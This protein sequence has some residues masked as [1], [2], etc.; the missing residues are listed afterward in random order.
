VESFGGIDRSR[1]SAEYQKSHIG[2]LP[3]SSP[4]AKARSGSQLPGGR[5]ESWGVG[6]L[7]N[8]DR[9]TITGIDRSKNSQF[10]Q[11]E[12]TSSDTI[13]GRADNLPTEVL[14]LL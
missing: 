2:T 7:Q 1:Q 3:S 10:Y 9:K 8:Q 5:M 4:E 13:G 12:T 14:L 11:G 6:S